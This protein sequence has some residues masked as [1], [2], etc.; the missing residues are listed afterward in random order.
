L[1]TDFICVKP[2][3]NL[4]H[5][6]FWAGNGHVS[7]PDIFNSIMASK[8]NDKIISKIVSELQKKKNF[9]DNIDGVMNNTGP[10]F[11]TKCFY[12]VVNEDDKCIIYPTTYFFP[13]P[14]TLRH[15]KNERLAE[16]FIHKNT[17][18]I[19]LWKTTWQK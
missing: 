1:D 2:F 8:P 17:Y 15:S 10:Y 16:Q 11:I 7:E 14:A 3:D 6:D 4:L 13:F 18:A 5:L 19:H 9:V 12:D